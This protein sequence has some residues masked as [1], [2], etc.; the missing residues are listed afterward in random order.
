[1]CNRFDCAH[2]HHETLN[3]PS[4]DEKIDWS[5]AIQ[6]P[7][8]TRSAMGRRA[9]LV[10]M[11]G[12]SGTALIACQPTDIARMAPAAP[13]SQTVQ[14][15]EETWARIRSETSV[16]RNS[17]MQNA[18]NSVGRRI[19]QSNGIGGQWEFLVFQGDSANAFALPGGKVGFYE[20]IFRHMENDAQLATVVGH[21]IAHN[22]QEHAAQRLGASQMSQLGVAAISAAFGAGNPGYADQIAALMGA[23]VQYGM[24]M[25]FGRDQELE[26]DRVGLF[27]MARGGYDPRES[28]DFWQT[29]Q[30]QAGGR[31]PE[32]LSTHPAGTSRLQ[33]LDAL[34][35]DALNVYRA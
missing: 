34:M 12:V 23:G 10:G 3:G 35:P 6:V 25:P 16:S 24:I 29:M 21:E 17:S 33:Q 32:W 28:M 15:G 11:V 7:S 30:A 1:M 27:Y 31:G 13:R 5:T 22:T 26:A 8:A 14:L 19:V 4:T 2:P 20:G 18:L 9:V